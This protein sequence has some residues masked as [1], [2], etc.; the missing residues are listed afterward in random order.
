MQAGTT[1]WQMGTDKPQS[2]LM[3]LYVGD[4]LG[5]RPEMDADIPLRGKRF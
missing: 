1:S 3:G 4:A 5:L 2:L